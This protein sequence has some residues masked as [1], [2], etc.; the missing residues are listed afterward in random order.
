MLVKNRKAIL[1]AVIFL[2]GAAIRLYDLTDEPLEF[3]ITRQLRSAANARAIY[4]SGLQDVDQD[5]LDFSTDQLEQAGLIEPPLQEFFTAQIYKLIGSEKV[6]AGRLVSIFFWLVGGWAIFSLSKEFS[7][8]AGGIASLCFYLFLPFGVLFSRALM[9]DP[10]MVASTAIAVWALVNWEKNQTTK[11]AVVTGLI[12]GYAILSKSVAGFIL[13][14]PFAFF[15]LISL[16]FKQ[17]VRSKQ[18]WLIVVLTTLPNLAYYYYGIFVHGGLLSSFSARFFPQLLADSSFYV[19]WLDKIEF[20]FG[21][22]VFLFGVIGIALV[23]RKKFQWL[24]GGWLA[25]YFLYGFFFPYHIWTHDYYHLPLVPIIAAMLAPAVSHLYA[26]VQKKEYPVYRTALVFAG[27]ALLVG[28]NLWTVRVELAKVD[29][30]N[31]A[32]HWS[33]IASLFDDYP[34]ESVV[35]LTGD[36]G[37][38]LAFYGNIA[39]DVWP[40]TGDIALAQLSGKY[41]TF[42][43]LWADIEEQEYR[44]F[45]ITAFSQLELQTELREHLANNYEV[46]EQGLG[47]LIFDLNTPK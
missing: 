17:A 12:T 40:R 22:I 27:L 34:D 47:Y 37:R 1:L 46:F 35:A 36:Y 7:S 20:K 44:F 33:F 30:R 13:I 8:F 14:L 19:R 38:Q 29:Y 6:W 10:M 26:S 32:E 39:V 24:L 18:V 42:E 31:V 21:L 43:K 11:W 25:G 41:T 16:G 3:H 5:L 9:P 23:E 28:Y 2:L 15:I 4:F 45:L